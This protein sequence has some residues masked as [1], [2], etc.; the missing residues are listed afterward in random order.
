MRKT[1]FHT[2]T[3]RCKHA[4]GLDEDYVLAAIGNGYEVLGFS[5]HVPWPYKKPFKTN[6]RMDMDELDDYVQS[7]RYLKEKY[8]DQIEILL[9]FECEYF[10]EY[11]DYLKRMIEEVHADYII[12]GNHYYLSDEL[13]EY[14]GK[15]T[16][17]DIFMDHYLAGVIDGLKTGLYAYLCHP[18]LFMRARK[19]FDDKAREI[20]EMICAYAKEND[21][22]LEYNLEGM[23]QSEEV[24]AAYYP[25]PEFWQIASTYHNKVIIGVDAHEAGSLWRN[26]YRKQALQTIEELDLELVDDIKRR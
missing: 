8:R 16:D 9:G 4:K 19:V 3:Y 10:P 23:R 15:N 2:H 25:C 14:Y 11:M 5:D 1:N 17:Q 22:I 20:S 18:D 26:D 7:V 6:T 21:V 12:F 13:N 24:K